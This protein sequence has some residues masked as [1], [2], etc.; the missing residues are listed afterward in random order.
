MAIDLSRM[1]AAALEAALE[2]DEKPEK[3]RRRGP[4]ATQAV[5]AGAVVA[6]AARVAA[7]KV[8]RLPALATAVKLARMPGK[9]RDRFSGG[10]LSGGPALGS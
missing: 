9:V 4:T 10:L 6:A 8:P 1:A 5:V 3:P 7:T 2:N